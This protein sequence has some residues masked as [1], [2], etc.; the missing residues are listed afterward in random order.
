MMKP[1]FTRLS[2]NALSVQFGEKA[3]Q[4][5]FKTIQQFVQQLKIEP[6][7]GLIEIVPG[8]TNVV[9]FF[10]PFVITRT[11][12]ESL[13]EALTK[14]VSPYLGVEEKQGATSLRRIPVCYD[15]SLAPDL[16]SLAE[17]KGFSVEE[18][19]HRH[20]EATYLVH[21]IGFAPGFPFLGGMNNSLATPRKSKPRARVAAGSVGIAGGQTGIY[22]TE[23]PGG[24]QLIGQTPLVLFDLSK[25]QPSL[26]R[27]GDHVQF[28]AISLTSFKQIKAGEPWESM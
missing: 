14:Q 5:T 13:T 28:E 25:E 1:A 21:M 4:Q 12:T 7:N 19:I 3:D 9:L 8:Y 11:S 24:W 22:P 6:F 27:A 10:D 15:E 23:T 16:L 18:V 26:L 2:E 20:T 17:A